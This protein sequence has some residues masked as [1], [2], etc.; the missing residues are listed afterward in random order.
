ME[1]NIDNTGTDKNEY[2]EF[3]QTE[4]CLIDDNTA[5]KL[6][7]AKAHCLL[8]AD[9]WLTPD[10]IKKEKDQIEQRKQNES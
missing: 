10:Q 6:M 8:G 5:A 4:D 9:G 7:L 3:L 1:K 2:Y